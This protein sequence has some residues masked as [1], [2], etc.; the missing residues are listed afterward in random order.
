MKRKNVIILVTVLIITTSLISCFGACTSNG[1]K[2]GDFKLEIT[3]VQVRNN[4]VVVSVE[5]KNISWHNGWIYTGGEPSRPST[6]IQFYS[7]D[8]I[9]NP[10]HTYTEHKVTHW[11]KC[12]QVINASHEFQLPKGTYT[13][14]VYADFA[15]NDKNNHFRFMKTTVVEV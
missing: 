13:I 9:E 3:D 6:M 5:F 12:K 7:T 1:L 15:C 8:E 10:D 4:R 11:I 2:E 14:T